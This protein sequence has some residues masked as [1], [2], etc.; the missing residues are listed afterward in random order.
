MGALFG[1]KLASA[2]NMGRAG[3][4]ARSV[5]RAARERGDIARAQEKAED[6][7]AELASLEAELS[8][9]LSEPDAAPEPALRKLEIAP[10]KADLDVERVALVWLPY[11]RSDGG[12]EPLFRI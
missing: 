10:R 7:R 2:T 5:S 12:A 11:R 9:A 1:R 4:A 6:L 8:S 3:T